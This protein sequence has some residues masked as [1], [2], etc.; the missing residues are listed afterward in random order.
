ML[1]GIEDVPVVVGAG[2]AEEVN[3]RLLDYQNVP[4]DDGR[5]V[6]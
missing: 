3:M 6:E 4:I 5:G 1:R 2:V